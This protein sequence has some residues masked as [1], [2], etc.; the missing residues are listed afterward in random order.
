MSLL[1]LTLI[2]S[3]EQASQIKQLTLW[4]IVPRTDNENFSDSE[5]DR[6]ET[7]LYAVVCNDPCEVA[8]E[9]DVD[10]SKTMSYVKSGTYSYMKN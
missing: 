2:L 6:Y 5:S 8:Q 9:D 1:F 3:I 4:A 7:I 10:I